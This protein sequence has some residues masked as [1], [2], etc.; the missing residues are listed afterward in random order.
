MSAGNV[1]L[2][3]SRL[4]AARASG[5]RSPGSIPG[6]TPASSP[7]AGTDAD[8]IV[9]MSALR[10]RPTPV[11]RAATSAE[12]DNSVW[13]SAPVRASQRYELFADKL[14]YTFSYGEEL[15]KLLRSHGFKTNIAL[16]CF[17]LHGKAG[18]RACSSDVVRHERARH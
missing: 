9:C 11:S 8:P 15:A 6:S 3:T 18:P 5:G 14:D 17:A 10:N 7:S 16:P 1:S 12:F 13:V 2:G 4:R